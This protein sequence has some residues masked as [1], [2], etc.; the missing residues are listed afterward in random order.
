MLPTP[1]TLKSY[2][3]YQCMSLSAAGKGCCHFQT[4]VCPGHSL[5]VGWWGIVASPGTFISSSIQPANHPF[6]IHYGGREVL[7]GGKT[8]Q[9][10][11]VQSLSH[12]QFFTAPWTAACQA[13]LSITNSQSS[14]KLTFIE[15]VM[16]PNPLILCCPLLLLPSI[17]PKLGSFQMS[18]LFALGGQNTGVSAL[19]SVLPMNTQD[20]FPLGWTACISLS[21]KVQ[22]TLKSLLQHHSSKASILHSAFFIVQLSHPYMTTGKTIP[23]TIWTF[24]GK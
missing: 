23:L 14:P 24:V 3:G 1:K 16:P 15:S 21:L 8:Y 18:Q 17:F 7:D 11:S 6:I 5:S 19:T 20:Q 12:V 13:S 10:S 9:L 4:E 2:L 22:R